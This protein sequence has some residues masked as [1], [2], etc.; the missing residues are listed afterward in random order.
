MKNKYNN[1]YTFLFFKIE[2]LV[3]LYLHKNYNIL[4]IKL[5]KLN[6]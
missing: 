3:K 6:T 1:Q 4:N 5:K 2:N